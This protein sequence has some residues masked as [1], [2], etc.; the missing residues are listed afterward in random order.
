VVQ[1]LLKTFNAKLAFS[2]FDIDKRY[3]SGLEL[4][5]WSFNNDNEFLAHL[6]PNLQCDLLL[7]FL[8]DWVFNEPAVVF[9]LSI[10]NSGTVFIVKWQ[11]VTVV[12]PK[13]LIAFV[14]FLL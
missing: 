8:G 10:W 13:N 2:H 5:L 3:D 1:V 11:F 7:K 12:L 14:D 4:I 9:K 6:W